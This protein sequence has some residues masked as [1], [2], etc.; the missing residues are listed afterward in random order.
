MKAQFEQRLKI[1]MEEQEQLLCRKNRKVTPYN[2]IVN[3]YEFPVLT[4]SHVPISWRYDLNPETNPYLAERIGVNG[5][6]NAGAI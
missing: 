1:L 3:R 5:V 6:F 2:G 4:A